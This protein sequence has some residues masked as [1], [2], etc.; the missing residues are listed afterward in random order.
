[1]KHYLPILCTDTGLQ[2]IPPVRRSWIPNIIIPTGI[3]H[4]MPFC[5]LFD[6]PYASVVAWMEVS[7]HN[8]EVWLVQ[9]DFN[10]CTV[11]LIRPCITYLGSAAH[12]YGESIAEARLKKYQ[13]GL[14]Q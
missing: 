9:W 8:K 4:P 10:Y 3:N 13:M 14:T 12:R 2:V 5:I 1:M 7:P 6:K 11:R